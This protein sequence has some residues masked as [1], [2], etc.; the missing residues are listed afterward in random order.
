M[1]CS[2][3]WWPNSAVVARGCGAASSS[4]SA[5]RLMR[6]SSCRETL[7]YRSWGQIL[8]DH[9]RRRRIE[10]RVDHL[11]DPRRNFLLLNA[12]V[13][14]DAP[15]RLRLGERQIGAA[16]LFV[17]VELFGLEPIGCRTAPPPGGALQAKR[18]G[19]IENDRQ[20]RLEFADRDPLQGLDQTRID[21]TDGALIDP[22][23][24]GE[25]VA[26]YPFAGLERWLDG[27]L[28]VILARRSEQHGFGF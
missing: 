5:C 17:K 18:D 26:H 15:P 28:D 27:A 13:D 19:H 8:V 11:P 4:S 16:Q 23:R 10:P 25:A 21:C 22:G 7:P 12:G 6:Q 1:P 20:V 24:I 2:A 14:D 3:T 9:G